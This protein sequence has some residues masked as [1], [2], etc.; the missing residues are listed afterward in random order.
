MLG[1]GCLMLGA[2]C[3]MLVDGFYVDCKAVGWV[4]TISL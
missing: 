4:E 2:G 3:R 1:A